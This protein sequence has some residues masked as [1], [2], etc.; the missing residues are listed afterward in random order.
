MDEQ[1][2]LELQQNIQQAGLW[3]LMPLFTRV[4]LASETVFAKLSPAQ[5]NFTLL[6]GWVKIELILTFTHHPPHPGESSESAI[7]LL[8]KEG[9]WG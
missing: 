1:N 4:R 2:F 5:S 7:R 9:L 8:Q 6:V 3:N